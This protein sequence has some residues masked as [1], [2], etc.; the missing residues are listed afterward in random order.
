LNKI[1]DTVTRAEPPCASCHAG[2]PCEPDGQQCAKFVNWVGRNQAKANIHRPLSMSAHPGLVESR[3]S[4]A[5]SAEETTTATDLSLL[6][7][8]QL[9][10]ELR[11]DYLKMRDS[12]VLVPLPRRQR[13]QRAV[14]DILSAAGVEPPECES[15]RPSAERFAARYWRA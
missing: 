7:D 11:S 15:G 2:T 9:P 5:H 3:S 12:D 4:P 1:R 13:I 14:A 10:I 8:Q 6:I